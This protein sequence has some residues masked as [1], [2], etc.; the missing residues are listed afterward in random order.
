MG[1]FFLASKYLVSFYLTL[2]KWSMIISKAYCPRS[3][4]GNSRPWCLFTLSWTRSINKSGAPLL[5]W[6][7][8]QIG[9]PVQSLDRTHRLAE[10]AVRSITEFLTGDRGPSEWTESKLTFVGY[11]LCAKHFVKHFFR[12]H[13][14]YILVTMKLLSHWSQHNPT[15]TI[16]GH[17][18]WN[19]RLHPLTHHTAHF[20]KVTACKSFHYYHTADME[21][22]EDSNS[23]LSVSCVLFFS[24]IL[25]ASKSKH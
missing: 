15:T 20:K 8:F 14:F 11:L 3:G 9:D 2:R 4:D 16:C 18:I 17:G 5:V 19:T 25:V 7:Y 23:N 12:S 6:V 21:V 24:S 22:S 13:Y 10:Q 1:T